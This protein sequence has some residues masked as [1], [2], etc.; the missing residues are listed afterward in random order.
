MI[1]EK[2]VSPFTPLIRGFRENIESSLG[3]GNTIM[4]VLLPSHVF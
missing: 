2:S 4:F 1:L 3:L